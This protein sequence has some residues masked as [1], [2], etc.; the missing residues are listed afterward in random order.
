[1]T[2]KFSSKVKTTATK[3]PL[4]HRI[5]TNFLVEMNKKMGGA[6]SVLI[7]GVR[8]ILEYK[9]EEMTFSCQG[10]VVSILGE[11]LVCETYQNGYIE[12]RGKVNSLLLR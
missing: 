12:V 7:G 6:Y 9:S 3:F 10:S 1:M 2:K 5:E 11:C 4:I 8:R